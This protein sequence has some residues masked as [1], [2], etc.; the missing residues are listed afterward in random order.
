MKK[1]Y[2]F[3]KNSPFG[4]WE[5]KLKQLSISAISNESFSQSQSQLKSQVKEAKKA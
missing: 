3:S 2:L 4:G 5:S 1:H